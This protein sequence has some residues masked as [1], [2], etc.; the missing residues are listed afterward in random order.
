MG[1]DS[2]EIRLNLKGKVPITKISVPIA[3][4]LADFTSN[5][6]RFQAKTQL[7]D[8]IDIEDYRQTL[9]FNHRRLSFI[10]LTS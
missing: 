5:P 4:E 7:I 10:E 1:T 8:T 3:P 9:I 2:N 6:V